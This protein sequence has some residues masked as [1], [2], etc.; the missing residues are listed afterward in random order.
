[1]ARRE[2]SSN[3]GLRRVDGVDYAISSSA[4]RVRDM[5]L[6]MR[7][8]EQVERFGVENVSDE[9]LL[10]IVLR[11]GVKGVNVIELARSL[12]KEYGSLTGIA[13]CSIAEMAARRGMGEVKAQVLAAALEL[14]KRLGE[15][16]APERQSVRHPEDAARLLRAS[17]RTLDA[18]MFWVLLLDAKNCLKGRP[19]N[20]SK[21]LLDASLVHPREVFRE[22]IRSA[23]AAV[24]IA[25]NHPS[26]DPSPS[27]EDIRITRQMIE[28]GNIIDIK[29]LDHVIL[30]KAGAAGEKDY[31]SMRE[32]GIV[33]F[34]G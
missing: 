11:S 16:N 28:A 15:E 14:A 3:Q 5:P 13:S 17:V 22:A 24:V 32:H 26:G 10:A 12:L 33:N 29:V 18:E 9:V 34:D 2:S 23:T 31:V 30:G 4:W 19:V 25:H 27:S 1:M 21:G 6:R 7:P 20:I 8:R